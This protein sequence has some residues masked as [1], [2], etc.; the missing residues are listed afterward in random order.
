MANLRINR[1][2]A[3]APIFALTGE[4]WGTDASGATRVAAHTTEARQI[5]SAGLAKR[6]FNNGFTNQGST[7]T[8]FPTGVMG[9]RGW[10]IGVRGIWNG[11]GAGVTPGLVSDSSAGAILRQTSTGVL[12]FFIASGTR[13]T[14]SYALASGEEF[15][16]LLYGVS[17][18]Y[19]LDVNGTIDTSSAAAGNFS[20][21]GYVGSRN[22]ATFDGSLIVFAWDGILPS[23]Q[24]SEW[25]E[26]PFCVFEKPKKPIYFGA[27]AAGGPV[28]IDLLSADFGFTGNSNQPSVRTSLTQ[29][30]FDFTANSI[31]SKTTV[32][33]TAAAFNFTANAINLGGQTIIDLS[34]ATFNF[35]AN[36]VNVIKDTVIDLTAA[37]FNFAAKVINISTPP[38]SGGGSSG[39]MFMALAGFF[40]KRRYRQKV[41]KHE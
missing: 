10:T 25:I 16:A 19:T 22:G 9:A 31:Q 1:S 34:R 14:S 36:T 29:A 13:I 30:S 24:R 23:L 4:T 12:S 38:I 32:G 2:R 41:G 15:Y 35:T 17:G 3:W 27:S 37:A 7:V 8:A 20:N 33:L 26:D 18:N 21:I 11:G 28:V 40:K 6:Y 5:T 39:G